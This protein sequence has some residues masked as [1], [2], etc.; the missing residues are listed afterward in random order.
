MMSPPCQK[1]QHTSC[2]GSRVAYCTRT[3]PWIKRKWLHTH[4]H[5]KNS[6]SCDSEACRALLERKFNTHQKKTVK[7]SPDRNAQALEFAC[8]TVAARPVTSRACPER[9]VKDPSFATNSLRIGTTCGTGYHRSTLDRTSLHGN[10][11]L[12]CFRLFD[13]DHC[14]L[15]F[16]LRGTDSEWFC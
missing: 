15:L 2:N 12:Q 3:R 10:H 5:K 13:G 9:V 7:P 6:A 11:F 4:G 1:V 14:I 8:C 16:F